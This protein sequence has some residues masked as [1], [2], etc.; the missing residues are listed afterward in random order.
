M[1]SLCSSVSY[2][3]GCCFGV[4]SAGAGG[5]GTYC[6]VQAVKIHDVYNQCCD[7]NNKYNSHYPCPGGGLK[8]RAEFCAQK[9]DSTDTHLKVGSIL[10]ASAVALCCLTC[11]C[12]VLS[13]SLRRSG[14]RSV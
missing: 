3:A 14:Y 4:V 11:I 12:C 7:G 5:V 13:S 6:L 8:E 2:A 10:L 9:S 1:G